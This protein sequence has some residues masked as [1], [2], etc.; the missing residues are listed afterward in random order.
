M[1]VT[2]VAEVRKKLDK[3]VEFPGWEED[4]P[5]VAR[6][7]RTSLSGLVKREE[8]PN[9]LLPVVARMMGIAEQGGNPLDQAKPEEIKRFLTAMHSIAELLLIEPTYD[10]VG[11]ILTDEQLSAIFLYAQQGLRG[12]EPFRRQRGTASE[13]GGDLQDVGQSAE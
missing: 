2:N 8:L 9:D 11:D 1:Q 3:P 10:E 7:R 13:G 4:I 12:L 6:V 5:F